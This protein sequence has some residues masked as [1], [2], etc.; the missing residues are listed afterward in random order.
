MKRLTNSGTKETK[1]DVKIREALNKLAEYED[2]GLTPEQ[3]KEMDRLY[4]EKNYYHVR[5]A[6]EKHFY[7]TN[8]NACQ[9]LIRIIKFSVECEKCHISIPK[10]FE[11]EVKMNR[12]EA[13]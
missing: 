9:G 3:I 6:V 2:T 4:A 8:T 10:E 1:S 13:I 7:K 5:F 12:K 11:L